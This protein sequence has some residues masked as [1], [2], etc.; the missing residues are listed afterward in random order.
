MIE[1]DATSAFLAYAKEQR[2]ELERVEE[3]KIRTSVSNSITSSVK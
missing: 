3:E 1:N 2:A